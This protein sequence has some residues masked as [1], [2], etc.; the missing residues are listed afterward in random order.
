MVSVLT[1]FAADFETACRY[2]ARCGEADGIHEIREA[3][4]EAFAVGHCVAEWTAWV[5]D[6]AVFEGGLYHRPS[7]AEQAAKIAVRD[8]L[9]P[10]GTGQTLSVLP[11]REE[12][13]KAVLDSVPAG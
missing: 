5:R 12:V 7:L 10:P 2:W 4:R 1:S 13:P 8:E 11:T 6:I 3:A 9:S